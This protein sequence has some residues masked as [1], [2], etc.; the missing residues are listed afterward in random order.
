V[1]FKE[2]WFN[3]RLPSSGE[4]IDTYYVDELSYGVTPLRSQ[5]SSTVIGFLNYNMRQANVKL[6]S[7]YDRN[8]LTELFVAL[9][10]FISMITRLTNMYLKG[11]QGYA[12]NKS[13]I[14]KVY[15]VRKPK[16]KLEKEERE[17]KMKV[18]FANVD[19]N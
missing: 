13:M 4:E 18:S 19:S 12:L 6:H 5:E 15:S 9:G 11:Y 10:G 2:N 16:S 17:T 8:T 7:E 1:I 3:N 14:K